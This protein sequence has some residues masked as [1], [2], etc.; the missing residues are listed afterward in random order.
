MSATPVDGHTDEFEGLAG[1]AA[2]DVLHGDDLGRLQRH[3][4]QC[5]RCQLMVR[6]DGEALAAVSLV[7]PPMDPSSDFKVR[8]MQRA[9]AE[10]AAGDP[11]RR[12]SLAEPHTVAEAPPGPA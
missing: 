3:A 7:A 5:E 8:L 12:G 1:L 9:A 11:A 10:L 4:A 2:L 6:L